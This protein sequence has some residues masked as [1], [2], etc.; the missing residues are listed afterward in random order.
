MSHVF[1][2]T[3]VKLQLEIFASAADGEVANDAGE[4]IGGLWTS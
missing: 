2:Q 1:K 3:D 4:G